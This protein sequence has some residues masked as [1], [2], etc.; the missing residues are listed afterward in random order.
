MTI[1][2]E[3][4]GKV[5][6]VTGGASGIGL[7]T[8]ELFV[9]EGAK[10]VIADIDPAGEVVAAR[11]GD[12]AAFKHT[13]VADADQIQDLVDF[14][15]ARFGGLDVMCNNAGIASSFARFLKDDFRDFQRVVAVNL[16]GVMVGS[17][18]AARFMA[19]N[20]GGSI[21]NTTSIAAITPGIGLTAYRISKA[22]VIHLSRSIA[23]DLAEY[24]IRV[25]CVAPGAIAT[26]IPSPIDKS[27]IRRKMQPLPHAGSPL[28]IANAYL[29]LAS[30]RS[31]HVT[32]IVLPVDAGLTTGPPA[33]WIENVIAGSD[34]QTSA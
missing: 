9:Q 2:Q 12:S 24:G 5:A 4:A 11:L 26:L 20:G 19:G 30:E 18:R 13:D 21:I 27:D 8:A 6:I 10:V 14:A 1:E 16:F 25:N 3:L 15:A 22:G 28:D 31:A 32:G 33:S 17:Q 7:A 23:L 34:T 29:Y